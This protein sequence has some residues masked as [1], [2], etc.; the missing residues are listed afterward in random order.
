MGYLD[1]NCPTLSTKALQSFSA[2]VV[3]AQALQQRAI[4]LTG[5]HSIL[6]DSGKPIFSQLIPILVMQHILLAAL[7]LRPLS[8]ATTALRTK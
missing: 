7:P 8:I 6:D 4:I 1:T 3:C 2:R 5:Q